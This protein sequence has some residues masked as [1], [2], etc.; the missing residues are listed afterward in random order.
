M[1]TPNRHT[2]MWYTART[3][4]LL[5]LIF[6]YSPPSYTQNLFVRNSTPVTMLMMTNMIHASA[7][8]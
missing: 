8:P 3:S 7:A 6:I 1:A 2:R 5:A 4:R